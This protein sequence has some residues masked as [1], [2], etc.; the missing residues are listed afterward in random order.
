MDSLYIVHY[1]GRGE[2]RD[3]IPETELPAAVTTHLREKYDVYTFNKAFSV[4]DTPGAI[5][6]MWL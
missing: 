3:S 4:T 2:T 1:Y 6:G 5:T